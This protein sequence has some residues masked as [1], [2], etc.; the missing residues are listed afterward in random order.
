MQIVVLV[1]RFFENPH[2]NGS[3]LPSCNRFFCATRVTHQ[4]SEDRGIDR[5]A[6]IPSLRVGWYSYIWRASPSSSLSRLPV[7]KY[8]KRQG[9]ISGRGS[10]KSVK[11]IPRIR[12]ITRIINAYTHAW[13]LTFQVD[14]QQSKSPNIPLAFF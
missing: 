1:K 6:C 13:L 7:S 10:K 3:E 5:Q 12:F 4:L 11:D 9:V 14:I 2:D 8:Q